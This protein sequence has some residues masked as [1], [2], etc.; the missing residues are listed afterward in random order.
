MR[1]SS[2]TISSWS[3]I[4]YHKHDDLTTQLEGIICGLQRDDPNM[5]LLNFINICKLFDYPRVWQNAIYLR[6]FPLS[7]S[8]EE[9]LWLNKLATYSIKNWWQVKGYFIERFFPPSKM[10]QLRDETRN[11]RKLPNEAL[12]ET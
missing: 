4:Q 5:H 10:L 2:T 8:R 7:L 6:L 3:E 12:Y 1:N 9:T 11:F